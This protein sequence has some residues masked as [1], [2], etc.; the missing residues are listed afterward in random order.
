MNYFRRQIRV[1]SRA[2]SFFMFPLDL[3]PRSYLLCQAGAF[4][5]FGTF[6][7]SGGGECEVAEDYLAFMKIRTATF[8]F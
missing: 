3:P 2:R 6:T 4:A 8:P 1:S 5:Y 7:R